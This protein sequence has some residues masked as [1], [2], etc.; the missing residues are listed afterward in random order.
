M[1]LLRPIVRACLIGVALLGISGCQHSGGTG[2][3]ASQLAAVA[4]PGSFQ[5]KDNGRHYFSDEEVALRRDLRSR[6]IVA[7]SGAATD[8]T[9]MDQCF[10]DRFT[11][12]R[13]PRERDRHRA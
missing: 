4:Q 8:R 9:K 1:T 7:C 6:M 11:E 12:A 10:R 2:G 13:I 3:G 5:F